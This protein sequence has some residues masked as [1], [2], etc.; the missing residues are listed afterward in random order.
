MA[1][2]DSQEARGAFRGGCD[3]DG[4]TGED[5]D[6]AR[7]LPRLMNDDQIVAVNGIADFHS[8]RLDDEEID[9]GPAG[10][11]DRRTIGELAWRR[12]RPDDSELRVGQLWKSDFFGFGH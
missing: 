4:A 7:E 6:V 2:G 8:A 10:L 5:V 3:D 1:V 12:Q 11:K 9:L